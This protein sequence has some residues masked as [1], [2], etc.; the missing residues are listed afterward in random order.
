MK[1][2]LVPTIPTFVLRFVM[3]HHH[4]TPMMLTIPPVHRFT[5]PTL[6][7]QV[8][9]LVLAV[10]TCPAFAFMIANLLMVLASF[11]SLVRVVIIVSGRRVYRCA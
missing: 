9:P 3:I 4:R 10:F 6:T 8:M 1:P 7:C 11:K 5:L 2:S